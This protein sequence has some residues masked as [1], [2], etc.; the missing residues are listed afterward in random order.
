VQN[1]SPTGLESL[2]VSMDAVQNR[3]ISK[4]F[5]ETHSRHGPCAKQTDLLEV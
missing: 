2:T 3:Q 1:R 4:R 5:G